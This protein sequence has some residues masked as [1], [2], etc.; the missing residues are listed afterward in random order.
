MMRSKNHSRLSGA[1]ISFF[2]RII[3]LTCVPILSLGGCS[4]YSDEV[5]ANL[6]KLKKTKSC[7]GCDELW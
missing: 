4:K 1:I 6:T 5:Q 2:Q 3:I 7:S